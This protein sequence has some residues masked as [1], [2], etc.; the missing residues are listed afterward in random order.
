MDNFEGFYEQTNDILMGIR[1]NNSKAWFN[2]NR[3][4]Y[5]KY[6]HEPMAAFAEECY[7]LMNV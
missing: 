6:V 7:K 1:F 4:A 2:E 5:K 3:N